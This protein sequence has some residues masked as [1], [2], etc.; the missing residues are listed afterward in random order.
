M[1]RPVLVALT[2]LAAQTAFA[3]APVTDRPQHML[4]PR[5]QVQAEAARAYHLKLAQLAARHEL[6]TDPQTLLRVR[7]IC[8]LLIAQAALLKPA[9]ASWPWEVHIT[10]DPEVAAFSMAGGKLLVGTHFIQAYHLSDKELAVA[11]AHEIGHVIAE[12]VREQLSTALTMDPPPPHVTRTM[13]DVINDMQSDIGLYLRLLPLSRL[14]EV[15][16]DDI[17]VELA[18][19]TGVSPTAIKS[20]YTKIT[21][22]SGGQTI[23][24]THGP[25]RAR[26]A[27]AV[28]M[29]DFAEPEYE[30]SR[31]ER[32]PS[33]AL[34]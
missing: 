19:R 3:G 25:S 8:G 27:F 34:R 32:L 14:Q 1:I 16:A 11:L 15:E 24:D 2:L 12:H 26:E 7:R 28:S 22:H 18:A 21:R 20:F 33:Y 17:G 30:A 6:D 4:F 31:G 13:D 5:A 10:S 23:F 9:A 29:A